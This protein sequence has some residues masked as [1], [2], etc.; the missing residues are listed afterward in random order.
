[1]DSTEMVFFALAR[2][3]SKKAF[4]AGQLSRTL[5]DQVVAGH[6]STRVVTP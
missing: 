3:L 2:S 4:A 6:G 1:M 5:E